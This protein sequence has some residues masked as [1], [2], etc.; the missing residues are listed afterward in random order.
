MAEPRRTRWLDFLDGIPSRMLYYEQ[1]MCRMIRNTV[2]FSSSAE[3]RTLANVLHLGFG[4]SLC[5]EQQE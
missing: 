1:I 5:G 3:G 4:S 2:V